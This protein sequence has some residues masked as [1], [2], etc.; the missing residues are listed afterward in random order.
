MIKQKLV[1]LKTQYLLIFL[2]IVLFSLIFFRGNFHHGMEFDEVFRINNIIP[3]LNSN[4]EPYEQ[5][6][7]SITVLGFKIPLMYKQYISSLFVWEYIPIGL[8]KDYTFGLRFLYIVFYIIFI[9]GFF[10]IVSKYNMKF[11]YLLTLMVMTSPLL[12][13]DITIGFNGL[14]H[15]FFITLALHIFYKYLKNDEKLRYLFWASFLL[16]FITN[17]TFYNSWIMAALF[18]TSLIFYPDYWKGIILSYKKII[19]IG[20]GV[21]IGLFNYIVYNIKYGFPT[22]KPLFLKLFFPQE[23]N[24]NPIDYHVSKPLWGDLLYKIGKVQS[25]FGEYYYLYILMFVI[26]ILLYLL[27]LVKM[28]RIKRFQ[29]FKGYYFPL[30]A[31]IFTFVFILISPNAIRREHYIRLIPLIEISFLLLLSLVKKF[32]SAKRVIKVLVIILPLSFI[33]LNFYTSNQAVSA[34]NKTHGRGFYSPAIFELNGYLK[35]HRIDSKKIIHL[36]WGMYAQLYFFNKGEYVINS[37]V[38]QLMGTSEE[39]DK[40]NILHNYFTSSN[41]KSCDKLYFPLYV[42][43]FNN[44]SDLFFKF[45]K[46]YDGKLAIEQTFYE[47]DGREVFYLY[48]LDNVSAFVNRIHE[49]TNTPV[50]DKN[51]ISKYD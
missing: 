6:I 25:F 26:V 38:F 1:S 51:R 46:K 27:L 12:Y 15:V 9:L 13:P 50:S 49:T 48:R 43:Q 8:F 14:E 22:I 7:C 31:L 2:L 42:T 39:Q 40:F 16:A 37:L 4:A 33:T 34:Y 29:E 47:K 5:S 17:F 23:Y 20:L 45:I 35:K 24:K 11:A 32:F 36:Q 21:F 18:F 28:F 10:I 19:T 3:Y 41:I 44:I 30:V